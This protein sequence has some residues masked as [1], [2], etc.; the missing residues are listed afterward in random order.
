[1]ISALVT[2]HLGH[3]WLA[4][5][6][7]LHDQE[8]ISRISKA[9]EILKTNGNYSWLTEKGSLVILQNGVEFVAI[10]MTM[11]LA[12]LG[13]GPG[14]FSLDRLIGGFKQRSNTSL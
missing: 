9:K 5:G 14:R 3:G 1:M 4:I 8:I 6:D 13:T 2:V 12:I 7:S 10:Y 11:L